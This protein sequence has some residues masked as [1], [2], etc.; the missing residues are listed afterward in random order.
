MNKVVGPEFFQTRNAVSAAPWLL[1]KLLVRT[2]GDGEVSRHII[3][4]TEAYNGEEDLA[5]HASKGRTTRTDVLYRLGGI[6]YVYLCYGMHEMLNLVVGPE[7]IPAAV[8]IRGVQDI[9]GPG[10]L[11]KKLAIGRAL[12]GKPADETSGLH[13]ED[14]GVVVPKKWIQV[15]PRIGVDYAGVIWAAKPWRFILNPLWPGLALRSPRR[16]PRLQ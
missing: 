10:R 1:G 8:L 2:R 4:E 12:N 6:W 5:C 9:S 11:T 16:Q 3:T 13:I 15:S 14:D 7:G